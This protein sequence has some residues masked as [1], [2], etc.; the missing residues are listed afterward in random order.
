MI[1]KADPKAEY[2]LLDVN[3]LITGGREG[4]IA[5]RITG[6]SEVEYIQQNYIVFANPKKEP[7]QGD[8]VVYKNNGNNCIKIYQPQIKLYLVGKTP[9][10]QNDHFVLGVVTAHLAVHS[11]GVNYVK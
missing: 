6:C 9:P 8:L 4:F 1:N 11:K 7:K 5:Y 10:K 3:E 2:E